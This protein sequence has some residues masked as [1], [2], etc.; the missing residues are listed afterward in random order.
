MDSGVIA[1]VVMVVL[2]GIM[3]AQQWW[4]RGPYFRR[5]PLK[6]K[7]PRDPFMLQTPVEGTVVYMRSVAKGEPLYAVKHDANY[8]LGHVDEDA[9]HLGIFM[10]PFDR[11]H[12]SAPCDGVVMMVERWAAGANL[13]MLDLL[14]YIRVMFFRRFDGW[15]ERHLDGW[16]TQNE[17]VVI[18]MCDRGG[19]DVQLVMIGDKYVNKIETYVGP[20]VH[21]KKGDVLGFIR[22]GSQVDIVVPKGHWRRHVPMPEPGWL[23]VGSGL[24][25]G[26]PLWMLTATDA[27]KKKMT[28][29]VHQFG[30]TKQ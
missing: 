5:R 18:H 11:H 10:T 15:L 23:E 6:G 17:R 1:V 27:W 9:W 19:R 14:E 20:G 24:R 26:D 2:V 16:I 12:V 4:L 21:V 7:H 30:R 25:C 8:Y 28:A 22:R 13:P 29:T 3:V